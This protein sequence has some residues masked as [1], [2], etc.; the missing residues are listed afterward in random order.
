MRRRKIFSIFRNRIGKFHD[1][2]MRCAISIFALSFSEDF[3]GFR[4]SDAQ[5]QTYQ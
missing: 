3:F 5:K 2:L 4:K 1:F